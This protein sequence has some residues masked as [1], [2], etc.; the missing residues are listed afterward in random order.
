MATRK[1]SGKE[2]FKTGPIRFKR[3][4]FRSGKVEEIRRKVKLEE[5]KRDP[6]LAFGPDQTPPP[7]SVPELQRQVKGLQETISKMSSQHTEELS[8]VAVEVADKMSDKADAGMEELKQQLAAAEERA[9]KSDALRKQVVDLTDDIAIRDGDVISLKEEIEVLEERL[10]SR[11]NDIEALKS[12]IQEL[13]EE[14][15]T[16]PRAIRLQSIKSIKKI[17]TSEDREDEFRVLAKVSSPTI[18][19][20]ETQLRFPV[21]QLQIIQN[22]INQ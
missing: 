3:E 9:A 20:A 10:S 12:E 22:A 13:E 7:M 18:P 1:M 2:G 11:K 19:T 6:L 21:S 5:V 14:P 15:P 8:L 17:E 16:I 4:D